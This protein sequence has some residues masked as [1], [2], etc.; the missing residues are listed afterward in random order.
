MMTKCKMRGSWRVGCLEGWRFSK[1]KL[2]DDKRQNVRQ[3]EAQ[4]L[5]RLDV[6]QK[7]IDDKMQNVR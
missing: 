1:R 3:L 7:Q 2:N 4:M 5:G 6:W